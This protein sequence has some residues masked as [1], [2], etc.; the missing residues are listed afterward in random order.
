MFAPPRAL[1]RASSEQ[2]ERAPVLLQLFRAASF[3]QLW[4]LRLGGGALPE[5]RG[6][7]DCCSRRVQ[8]KSERWK[9]MSAQRFLNTAFGVSNGGLAAWGVAGGAAYYFFYLPEKEKADAEVLRAANA[10]RLMKQKNYVEFVKEHEA[11]QT[12]AGKGGW[13]GGWFGGKK[14]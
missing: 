5:A 6:R 13:F 9:E 8:S 7:S 3:R 2:S 11:K 4:W 14:Q 1:A 12:K 10:E